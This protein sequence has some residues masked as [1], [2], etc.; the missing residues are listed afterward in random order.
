M[1][2]NAT[3]AHH[4]VDQATHQCQ[5]QKK[6]C[7]GPNARTPMFA[8]P[9]HI[10]VRHSPHALTQPGNHTFPNTHARRASPAK[11]LPPHQLKQARW[12]VPL[13]AC[14]KL[15]TTM[16]APTLSRSHSHAPSTAEAAPTRSFLIAWMTL[17]RLRSWGSVN[18]SSSSSRDRPCTSLKSRS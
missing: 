4:A 18:R 17:N 5:Q 14:I 10:P 15:H 7:K 3:Q 1:I 16:Q 8:S 2:L 6:S 11:T 9:E 13:R 12:R